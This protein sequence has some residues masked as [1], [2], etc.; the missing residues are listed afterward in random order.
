M[1]VTLWIG[2][3]NLKT[4]KGNFL[5][6]GHSCALV[7]NEKGDIRKLENNPQPFIGT[8]PNYSYKYEHFE[9]SKGEMVFIY[10]DG[11]TDALNHDEKPF[12]EENLICA[13]KMD[14][15]QKIFVIMF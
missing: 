15:L 10:T 7:K 4:R 14:S 12:G 6:A 13:L 5:N 8:F 3:I 11:V 9:L 2:Q 1:F